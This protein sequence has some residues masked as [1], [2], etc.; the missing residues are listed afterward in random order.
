MTV[1]FDCGVTFSCQDGSSGI[2]APVACPRSSEVAAETLEREASG[3]EPPGKS[4]VMDALA[5][6]EADRRDRIEQCDRMAQD[7][8]DFCETMG[9][10]WDTHEAVASEL[11]A[12]ANRLA[13]A[14]NDDMSTE[15]ASVFARDAI[16]AAER[17]FTV[18]FVR[19]YPGPD[20]TIFDPKWHAPK[21]FRAAL[22][23]LQPKN[24]HP[25]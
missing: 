5:R 2:M 13:T 25:S 14:A 9:V 7:W 6:C 18:Y 24:V 3:T 20:T 16:E 19:N 12:R 10:T 21:L 8:S 17:E 11:K 1:Y 22:R 23:A 4:Q 15:R